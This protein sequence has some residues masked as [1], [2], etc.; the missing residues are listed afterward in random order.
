MFT[1]WIPFVNRATNAPYSIYDGPTPLATVRVN[2]QVMSAGDE[3]DGVLWQPLGTWSTTTGTLN[4]RLNDN[5]NGYVVGDAV[6][7]VLNGIAPQEPEMNVD[8]FGV[9]IPTGDT[10]PADADGTSFGTVLA[11]TDSSTETFTIRNNGNAPLHLDGAPPVAISGANPQDFRVVTQPA[12]TVNPGESTTFAMI[13]HP[14]TTGLRQAEVS[15]AND[16][17]D[18]HP[19]TFAIQGVGTN[20][21]ENP[22]AGVLGGAATT[23]AITPLHNSSLPMDVSGD[24]AVSAVDAL[25][26]IQHLRGARRLRR[27]GEAI[28]MDVNGDGAVSPVDLLAVVDYLKSAGPQSQATPTVQASAPVA[29]PA[30]SSATVAAASVVTANV[31]LAAASGQTVA[32][33]AGLPASAVDQAMSQLSVP[34]PTVA[35]VTVLPVVAPVKKNTAADTPGNLLDDDSP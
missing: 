5:A 11:T 7:L 23:S 16:D 13:F 8:G 19:Y 6:R 27:L 12:S 34:T 3:S 33:P 22:G 10:L 15:I 29:S 32:S 31:A 28:T 1:K 14:T 9:S 25:I 18:E 20:G 4:V 30:A 21:D 17:T 26:L 35:K 24:R 2:Q